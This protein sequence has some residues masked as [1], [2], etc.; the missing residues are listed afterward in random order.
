V[1]EIGFT[2]ETQRRRGKKKKNKRESAEGAEGAE[3][4]MAYSAKRRVIMPVT[5]ERPG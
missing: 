5:S 4:N 1:S 2:T 3:K